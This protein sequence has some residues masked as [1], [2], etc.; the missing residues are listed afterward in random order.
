MKTCKIFLMLDQNRSLNPVKTYA[1]REEQSHIFVVF[2]ITYLILGCIFCSFI[3]PVLSG[4]PTFP[5]LLSILG[6]T[7]FIFQ[8]YQEQS[9]W[10]CIVFPFGYFKVLANSTEYIHVRIL[11]KYKTWNSKESKIQA[12]IQGLRDS[13]CSPKLY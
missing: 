11:F 1:S 5:H 2:S 7:K 4:L 8:Y 6:L 13:L 3:P 9:E 10:C 12:R